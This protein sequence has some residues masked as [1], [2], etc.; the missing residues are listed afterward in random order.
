MLQ[1]GRERR[2]GQP[3]GR[4]ASAPPSLLD[5]LLQALQSRPEQLETRE[6]DLYI[7][8]LLLVDRAGVVDGEKTSINVER[9][10]LVL[11]DGLAARTG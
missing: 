2:E 4:S 3:E 11:N 7:L 9:E 5:I 10:L 1:R 8:V 6:K